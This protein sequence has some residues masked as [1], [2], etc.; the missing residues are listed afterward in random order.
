VTGFEAVRAKRWL[1][2][3][4]ATEAVITARVVD[5][6]RV[7]VRVGDF[8]EGVV[9]VGRY[10]SPGDPVTTPL[11]GVRPAPVS[12]EQLYR[13]GWMFHGPRFAGVTE[14]ESLADNGITG[15]LTPL[16]APGALLDSAGQLIGHWMQVSHDV[17]QTVLPTGIGSV[18]F[19]GPPPT[20]PVRCT[21]W[22]REVTATEMRAD[23]EL[24]SDGVLWCRITGWTTR[25]FTTDDR[26][27]R[28][29]LRPGT[30]TLARPEE[31]GWVTVVEN[32]QDSATRDLIM[33]RYL[34]ATERDHYERLDVRAQRR[35]LL[36][37]IAVKDA[38]REWLWHR[39]A[40]S[41]H[42]A[43]LA[44]TADDRVRGAFAVPAVVVADA[45][46]LKRPSS[47]GRAAAIVGDGSLEITES[48]VVTWTPNRRGERDG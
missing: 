41:I 23:A 37:V 25:R 43:E 14:I 47:A 5:P 10:P 12:A 2:A 11:E 3:L 6:T 26:I 17:D 35:W 1:C 44:V 21:A 19:H 36:R 8:A 22:I 33:R 27:W 30:E 24:W 13:D 9:R 32:W 40:G 42:P 31:G 16:P 28:V 20:G 45:V 15:T 46:D 48:G 38:A 34:C 7:H 18:E 29:K 39:G 4:P